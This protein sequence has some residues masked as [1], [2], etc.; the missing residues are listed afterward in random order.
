MECWELLQ[1]PSSE[2]LECV[3]NDTW[4]R[5]EEALFLSLARV[6]NQCFVLM[7]LR[8]LRESPAISPKYLLACWSSFMYRDDLLFMVSRLLASSPCCNVVVPLG[9]LSCIIG[10]LSSFTSFLL[11]HAC[12]ELLV[13]FRFA[14]VFMLSGLDACI[15]VRMHQ[16]QNH[17]LRS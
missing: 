9:V 13:M 5:L 6:P 12:I 17:Q 8:R 15:D 14:A 1:E 10:L 16:N 11:A 2:F 7:P 4:D 3:P